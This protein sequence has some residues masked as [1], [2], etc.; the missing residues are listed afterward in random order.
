MFGES[1]G[2]REP[3]FIEVTQH[4]PLP[5]LPSGAIARNLFYKELLEYG[6]GSCRM[7]CSKQKIP[8]PQADFKAK[9]TFCNCQHTLKLI[10]ELVGLVPA[11]KQIPSLALPFG[12]RN[13]GTQ[14]QVVKQIESELIK[15]SIPQVD[16][17]FVCELQPKADG[18]CAF[19]TAPRFA[20][21]RQGSFTCPESLKVKIKGGRE[22]LTNSCGIRLSGSRRGVGQL[23][24]NNRPRRGNPYE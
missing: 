13:P 7:T 23:L 19:L 17:D 16:E 9:I 18:R 15:P 12:C 10:L 3:T 22:C 24:S 21:G 4:D 6:T 20:R 1:C 11:L 5:Q 8:K 14:W 2:L